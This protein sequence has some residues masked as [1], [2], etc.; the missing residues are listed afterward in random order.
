MGNEQHHRLI[1]L[2]HQHFARQR[3]KR[4]SPLSMTDLE[5]D[6]W[7]IIAPYEDEW[8]KWRLLPEQDEMRAKEDKE[9]LEGVQDKLNQARLSRL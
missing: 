4:G 5:Y 7:K 8:R 2:C 9:I 3:V 1:M 6:I